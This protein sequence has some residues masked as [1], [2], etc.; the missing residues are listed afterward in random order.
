MTV[1]QS[2]ANKVPGNCC[3][4]LIGSLFRDIDL[5]IV[6]LCV[7]RLTSACVIVPWNYAGHAGP[8]ISTQHEIKLP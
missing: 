8:A 3:A 6:L 1:I 5:V 7:G 2:L 4:Q